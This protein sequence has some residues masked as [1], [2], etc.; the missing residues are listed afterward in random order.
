VT[1]GGDRPRLLAQRSEFAYTD[2][3]DQALRDEP[4]AVSAAEQRHL[5]ELAHRRDRRRR[6]D[7]WKPARSLISAGIVS[8]TP[9]ADRYSRSDLRVIERTLRRIDQRLGA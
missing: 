6:L 8:F 9:A 3:V 4:E 7:A 2:R 1:T 5:T